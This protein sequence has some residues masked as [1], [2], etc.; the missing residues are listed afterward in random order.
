MAEP[1]LIEIIAGVTSLLESFPNRKF[2]VLSPE[3]TQSFDENENPDV[4]R[5]ELD[6]DFAP[7]S[8]TDRI[9][10]I[11]A[12]VVRERGYDQTWQPVK[13]GYLETPPAPAKVGYRLQLEYF[14]QIGNLVEVRATDVAVRK[15]FNQYPRLNLPS[16]Q[17]QF[18]DQR[19]SGLQMI[20]AAEGDLRTAIAYIRV[21]TLTVPV[22]EVP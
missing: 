2:K 15:L 10:K 14:C 18:I 9:G 19:H 22:I 11:N 7:G 16:E 13:T 8:N 12:W 1:T 6:L 4:L 21:Y 3:E 17:A 20:L 5:S